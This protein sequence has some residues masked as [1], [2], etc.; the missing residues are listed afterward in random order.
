MTAIDLVTTHKAI[1]QNRNKEA[2]EA[3]RANIRFSAA[4]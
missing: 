3:E 2:I 1:G 4:C